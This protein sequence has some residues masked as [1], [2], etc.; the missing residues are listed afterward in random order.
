MENGEIK[1]VKAK[2]L[3]H[4]SSVRFYL[5]LIMSF[6][7]YCT[8]LMRSNLGVAIVF[9]TG[10]V[11][12]AP[13]DQY[14]LT[15][16]AEPDQ[17]GELVVSTKGYDGT[18]NW[19][20]GQQSQLFSALFYGSLLTV[21][22]SGWI[23]DQFSPKILIGLA[24]AANCIFS[25]L[26]PYLANA[27]VG[28]FMVARF[29]MGLS[30]GFI[31]PSTSSMLAQWFPPAER[32]TA[33][34]V[35]TSG[36]QIAASFGVLVS[37]NLCGTQTFLAYGWPNIFYFAGICSLIFLILW[38]IFVSNTPAE[39]RFISE[40]EKNYLSE[41]LYDQVSKAGSG[42]QKKVPWLAMITSSAT[43]CGLVAQFS[44]NFS[45]TMLQGFLPSYFRDVLKLDLNSNGFYTAI[46][47]ITQLIFK[48]VFG[49]GADYCKRRG[50]CSDTAACK[51]LQTFANA[52]SAIVLIAMAVFVD[53]TRPT[54]SLILLAIFGVCFAGA[55]A[56]A[57][58]ATLSIA[59]PFTGTLT[60]LCSL[61]GCVANVATPTIIGLINTK[62]TRAEWS[63]IFF[64]AA[65]VNIICG[66]LFLV[67]GTAEVQPW[68]KLST[69]DKV[70][71]I[72]EI[73]HKKIIEHSKM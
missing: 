72:V 67:Y 50:W 2:P 21:G 58:T 30:E 33:A 53:C 49:I 24:I 70:A 46:P 25:F 20:A 54:L 73:S 23:S 44:F 61:S 14:N 6:C 38:L 48:N 64:I 27:G 71:P 19:S 16:L 28:Y 1:K 7:V 69:S 40:T 47:F 8:V 12:V 65:G 56:G 59:P 3:F 35:Y 32:S 51:I 10:D 62:G 29:L 68:A 63:L 37:S 4:P 43:L 34:A 26:S 52:G 55:M 41:K 66:L 13:I 11:P 60:S 36:N 45:N 57:F 17:C 31:F 22:V 9:D 18:L 5:L 39:N 15:K 42:K